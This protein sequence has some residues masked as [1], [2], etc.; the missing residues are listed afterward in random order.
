M[1]FEVLSSDSGARLSNTRDKKKFG[2]RPPGGDMARK[3]SARTTCRLRATSKRTGPP[4]LVTSN[5]STM[6]AP[7]ELPSLPTLSSNMMG[8]TWGT[9]SVALR[10]LQRQ[11]WTRVVCNKS[12]GGRLAMASYRSSSVELN[13]S[14]MMWIQFLAQISS[15]DVSPWKRVACCYTINMC[16]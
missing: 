7:A 5:T 11:R 12:S 1:Q 6:C 15:L 9:P 13:P 10:G 8:H 16:C 14:K 3:G 4:L 2:V